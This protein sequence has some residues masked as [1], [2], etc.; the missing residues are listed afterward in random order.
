MDSI[1]T[2]LSV[3]YKH[4][5]ARVFRV[6]KA[7][8]LLWSK[9]II[10]LC[11]LRVNGSISSPSHSSGVWT[12]R[13]LV[14]G[15]RANTTVSD[16]PL[17][18]WK[19]RKR[20]YRPP[21]LEENHTPWH[22]DPPNSSQQGLLYLKIEPTTF[23]EKAILLTALQTIPCTLKASFLCAPLST[24]PS[25]WWQC[26]STSVPF[27]DIIRLSWQPLPFPPP[28]LLLW[29]PVLTCGWEIMDQFHIRAGA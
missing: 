3:P 27:C 16:W 9:A 6:L 26:D 17:K 29:W 25:N 2:S 20:V 5:Y 14:I 19:Q 18:L 10:F 13:A 21:Y 15:E 11:L 4:V 22:R 23:L 24:S 28:S 12:Q 8:L 7:S 1:V